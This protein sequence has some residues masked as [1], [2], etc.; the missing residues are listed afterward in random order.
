MCPCF[1]YTI[2]E[3]A[4]GAWGLVVNGKYNGLVGQ[5]DRKVRGGAGRGGTG[6]GEVGRGGAGRDGAGRGGT[7][8]AGRGGAGGTRRTGRNGTA[9]VW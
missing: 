1:R 2:T 3:P 6:R 9:L 4:D 5:L 7:R 8:R